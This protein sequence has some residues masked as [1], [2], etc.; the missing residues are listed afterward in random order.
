MTRL[1]MGTPECTRTT[2]KQGAQEHAREPGV[3]SGVGS[4]KDRGVPALEV[5]ARRAAVG[6][7]TQ[8]AAGFLAA[9]TETEL[10]W[11]GKL[12]GEQTAISLF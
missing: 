6:L 8:D 4:T 12:S 10:E 2:L 9:P 5:R 11:A 3:A 7:R 1:K